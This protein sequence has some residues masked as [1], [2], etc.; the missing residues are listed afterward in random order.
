MQNQ[1]L[2][3]GKALKPDITQSQKNG[4]SSEKV[5]Y[6]KPVYRTRGVDNKEA[7]ESD[8]P[9]DKP[10]ATKPEKQ[11]EEP[12]TEVTPSKA[13]A[14]AT[15]QTTVGVRSRRSIKT[16]EEDLETPKV[17]NKLL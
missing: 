17:D 4:G 8:T 5:S 13:D 9:A 1:I 12:Q 3:F 11:P 10:T 14:K 16:K 6:R 15:K 2:L 7:E